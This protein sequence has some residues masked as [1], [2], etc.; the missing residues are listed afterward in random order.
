MNKIKL[1]MKKPIKF[2]FSFL[3]LTVLFLIGMTSCGNSGLVPVVKTVSLTSV[4]ATSVSCRGNVTSDGGSTIK[5]RGV[6]WGTKPNPTT[7]NSKTTSSVGTGEYVCLLSGLITD[8]KY[9]V[10]AYA[11]NSSGTS[12]GEEQSFTTLLAD[13]DGNIYKTVTIGTQVWMAENLRT[14]KYRNGNLI[15]KITDPTAWA[16]QTTG[17][18]CSYDN[19]TSNYTTYGYLYNWYAATDA[20]FIA[21]TGW[22]IPTQAEW[23]T[24]MNYL[25]GASVAG[26]VLMDTGNSYWTGSYT[27]ATNTSGFTALPGGCLFAPT[28]SSYGFNNITTWGVWWSTL[29][30]NTNNTLL[31][32]NGVASLNTLSK[33]SG[34]SVRCIRD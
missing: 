25:G 11:T 19:S 15:S 33:N 14:T 1:I 21:P 32:S 18:Y 20:R 7:S 30:S 31:I 22:H 27:G 2:S 29:D 26:P 24:L 5:T 6:C 17:A 8:T 16:S 3:T 10:R 13:V 9:Y 4:T 12:Y 23:T 28:G 34:C